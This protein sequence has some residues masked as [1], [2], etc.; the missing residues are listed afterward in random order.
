[1]ADPFSY[2]DHG[3]GGASKRP[4][5]TIEG[6]ATEITEQSAG[7]DRTPEA[8][9]A[10]GQDRADV[11][12][13]PANGVDAVPHPAQ[14]SESELKSF[15]THLAAG[16]LGGLVGVVGLAFAWGGLSGV[17]GPQPDIAALEARLAKLESAQPASGDNEA[18]AQLK[19]QVDAIQTSTKDTAPKLAD[20]AD[21]VAQLE[22]SLKAI[23]Q[24]AS[25]G[26]SVASA[27]AIT[28]Q[29][30]EAEQRL[31]AKIADALAKAE[32]GNASALQEMQSEIAEL[33]AKIGALAEL[34]T[35]DG[36][37]AG[38]E[39]TALTERLAKLEAALPEL[40]AAIGKDNEGAK[41]AAGAIAFANLRTAVSDGRPY[42]AE[43]DT[44]TAVVPSVGDL[45]VLPAYA[46]KGIPTVPE[47]ARA[48]AVAREAALVTTAPASSG[49]VVDTLMAS[50][51]SLVTIKRIDEPTTGE[52]PG[53]A[54]ARAKAALDS[55]D[56][57]TAVKEVETLDGAPRD[58]F[59][60][61]LG[62]AHARLSADETLM[63]LEST[64]LV[65]V[66]SNPQA[67]QQ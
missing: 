48:F 50:A 17:S 5:Q 34:G 44:I 59:A 10:A 61:W 27:A 32:A 58:A 60:A 47:L 2:Q 43:L 54:L 13:D 67:P 22:A 41:A 49:S 42:A 66:G 51:Q 25:E 7:G 46:E 23:S 55:E 19:S 3:L 40:A 35:G 9:A 37:A 18:L 36:T 6:T 64:L 33:K 1:M 56:L 53:A 20:L 8:E 15:V 57:A 29:I 26:G 63:Q 14:A 28:Q 30:A 11:A 39:L 24:S 52:G 16:V 45:G 21:R 65:S 38:A 31:D 4:A 62:Q 12:D